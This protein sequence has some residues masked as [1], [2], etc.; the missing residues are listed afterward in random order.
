[1]SSAALRAGSS[2]PVTSSDLPIVASGEAATT[3]LNLHLNAPVR[4]RYW[5]VWITSLPR[6]ERG[7]FSLGIAEIALLH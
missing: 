2:P 3:S 4:A 5:L 7:E 6:T 1:M